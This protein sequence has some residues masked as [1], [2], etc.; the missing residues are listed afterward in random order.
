LVEKMIGIAN[1]IR[2][3]GKMNGIANPIWL[4]GAGR[5]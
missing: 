2:L 3:Y 1:P 5:D 4:F